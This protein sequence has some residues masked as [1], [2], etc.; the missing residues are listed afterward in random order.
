MRMAWDQRTQSF[1]SKGRLGIGIMDKKQV[2]K[3]VKGYV[4]LVRKK[5]REKLCIYIEVDE[6]TW[7]YFEYNNGVMRVIS[8]KA[9][10]NAIITELKPDKREFKGP[11]DKGPYSFMLGTERS[12]RKFV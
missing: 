6:E 2:N 3:Y 9:D 7:Y 12:K 8:S 4:Q 10:F 5:T 11:R 1:K